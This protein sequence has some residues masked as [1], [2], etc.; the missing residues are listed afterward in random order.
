MSD[1]M[2]VLALEAA[3][4]PRWDA[5]DG[6]GWSRLFTEDGMFAVALPDGT[7]EIRARG[8]AELKGRCDLFNSTM[9]GVHSISRP[10][11]TFDGDKA[12]AVIPFTFAGVGREAGRRLEVVGMYKAEYAYTAEGWRIQF[13]FEI[14]FSRLTHDMWPRDL[15]EIPWLSGVTS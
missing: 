8:R 13:R 4:A 12:R 2:D 1:H 5:G 7:P 3:Y 6:A 11:L 10:D 9:R 15:P 14:P